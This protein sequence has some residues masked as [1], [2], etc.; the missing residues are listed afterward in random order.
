MRAKKE[1]DGGLLQVEIQCL[2]EPEV[3][4]SQ[5]RKKVSLKKGELGG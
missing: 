5:T 3:S 1:P 2:G 4:V